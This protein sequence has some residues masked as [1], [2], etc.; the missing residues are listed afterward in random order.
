LVVTYKVAAT[1][2]I[3][4]IEVLIKGREAK[5]HR[6]LIRENNGKHNWLRVLVPHNM[7]GFNSESN[8]ETDPNEGMY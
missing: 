2:D 1:G 3:P 7:N 4:F 6:P 8:L 5:K